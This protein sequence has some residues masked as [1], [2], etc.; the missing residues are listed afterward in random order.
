[1]LTLL[2][3]PS[4]NFQTPP[5]I[6][7]KQCITF[8]LHHHPTTACF[9]KQVITLITLPSNTTT[10]P[11]AILAKPVITLH[12][13]PFATP[14]GTEPGLVTDRFSIELLVAEISVLNKHTEKHFTKHL[15]TSTR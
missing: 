15:K 9:Q 6:L 5:P 12:T 10:P 3:H 14:G 2:Y 4:A 8:L 7:T 11:P 1:M 13:L